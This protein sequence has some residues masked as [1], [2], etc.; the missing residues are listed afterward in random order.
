MKIF[1]LG[2]RGFPDIQGGIERHGERLYP[3]LVNEQCEIM[4]FT[5]TPYVPHEKRLREWQGVRFYHLWSPRNRYLEAIVHTFLGIVI[6]RLHSPDFVHI[7][8]IG[9][10]LLAPLARLLGLKVIMTHHGPD[11]QRQKWGCCARFM[12][13]LG[14]WLGLRC[15]RHV[16]VVSKNVKTHLV[17]RFNRHDLEFIPNGVDEATCEPGSVYLDTFG[18]KADSYL[19]AVGRFV[20]EKGL[21]DLITAY[22]N[23]KRRD[24]KLVIVGGADHE[25]RYSRK[26]QAMARENPDIVMT[27]IRT[28]EELQCLYRYARV[29]VLPSYY[30]GLPITLLEALNFE[31]PVVVSDIPATREIALDEDV[32]FP[33]GNIKALVMKLETELIA[34]CPEVKRERYKRLVTEVYNWDIIARDTCALLRKSGV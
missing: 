28:H 14:E 33:P 16:I 29:F 6:S 8:A 26:L 24:C 25:T 32:Y 34:P 18:L 15:A 30:E 2:T 13:K 23:L 19:L 9:P 5:R 20:P 11:Y 3:R 17:N 31:C 12:L 22:S 21:H 27:G 10:A 7:H 1:V 4:V